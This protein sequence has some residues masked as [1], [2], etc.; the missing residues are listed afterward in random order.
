[1]T[2]KSLSIIIP[3]MNRLESLK[4]SLSSLSQS[5]LLPEEIIIIDQSPDNT[6]SES[7]RAYTISLHKNIKYYHT[8]FQSLTKARNMGI[9]LTS[10]DLVV[11]MDDD[12]SVQ[13]DTFI[14]IVN[15]MENQN[16]S[17]ISGIDLNT[18]SGKSILGYLF[19]HKSFF[20][21]HIGHISKGIYG[22]FPINC[23]H[24]TKTEWA[25]GFFFVI[26]KSLVEKWNLLWDERL[27]K[28]GYPE[29]L[30]FS[31]QYCQLSKKEGKQ[32]IITPDVAVYHRVSKEWR[33]TSLAV[34]MME[35]INREYLTYKWNLPF[36]YRFYTRIANIGTFFQ[37]LLSHNHP[38][39]VIKSQF[40][41][42][43]YRSDIKLG[44]LHKELYKK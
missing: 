16:V 13:R 40:Y 1:M 7:I 2:L 44:N 3:T 42:D 20:K 36:I 12:V 43:W 4:E 24:Q 9:R 27:I 34:T 18:S 6:L 23:S 35:I 15:I 30:D 38:F 33:E 8:N 11:F 25:M 17:L 39:D 32:C 19:L 31:Y 14:N 41:C 26:R 21:R 10:H 5:S 22:R 37:R 28:Y 29:D